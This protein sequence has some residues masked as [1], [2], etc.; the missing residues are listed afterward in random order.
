M[1]TYNSS[2]KMVQA[3]VEDVYK[4]V[5]DMDNITRLRTMI[6][7][8]MQEQY[9]DKLKA[10]DN[11]TT[12]TDTVTVS[13]G[14]IG[15]VKIGVMDR[16]ENSVVKYGSLSSPVDFNLWIQMKQT[17]PG[18]TAIKLTMKADLS[19]PMKLMLGSKLKDGIE[20]AADAI[21]RV[22]FATLS[23]RLV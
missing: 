13:A 19:F 12:T 11:V 17:E 2:V 15:A 14:P 7:A 4:V 16:Q 18:Q 3:N 1:E 8:A 23:A 9:G 22:P 20:Q 21:A 6:P 5:S 10:L